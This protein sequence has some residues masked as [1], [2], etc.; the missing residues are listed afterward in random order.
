MPPDYLDREQFI[1]QSPPPVDRKLLGELEQGGQRNNVIALRVQLAIH[2]LLHSDHDIDDITYHTL[3]RIRGM[4]FDGF[5]PR[6]QDLLYLRQHASS[7]CDEVLRF[8]GETERLIE[9]QGAHWQRTGYEG[10]LLR[11]HQDTD[12]VAELAET[13]G[14]RIVAFGSAR[15][16]EGTAEYDAVRWM[17]ATIVEGV[18]HDDGTTEQ[19]LTGAGPGIMAASN[20][21]AMEGAWNHYKR[22]L[23][24]LEKPGDLPPEEIRKRIAAFRLQLQS[25]GARIILPFEAGWNPYLQ[26]NLTIK[27]F[28]PRKLALVSG[29]GGRSMRQPK[30]NGN[31]GWHGKHPA[32]FSFKGGFGTADEEWEFLTLMQCGKTQSLVPFFAVGREKVA[33]LRATLGRMESEG[34]IDAGDRML[35]I[36]GKKHLY[37]CDDEVSALEQYLEHYGIEPTPALKSAMLERQQQLAL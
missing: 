27:S 28:G 8:V 6:I 15:L 10:E 33:A 25:I 14:G 20:R 31:N 2:S 11:Q 34:V 24:E 22:L 16:R 4:S 37:C 32:V 5:A 26:S 36:A 18:P 3:Q 17:L 21:G 9:E 19:V 7:N 35:S 1:R 23:R 13:L 29:A 12:A 30:M